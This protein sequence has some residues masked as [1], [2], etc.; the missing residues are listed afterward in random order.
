MIKFFLDELM[1]HSYLDES[2]IE[3][4]IPCTLEGFYQ[5]SNNALYYL[6]WWNIV[7]KVIESIIDYLIIKKTLARLKLSIM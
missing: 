2:H 1:C 4:V 3:V 6:I 5:Y 7:D